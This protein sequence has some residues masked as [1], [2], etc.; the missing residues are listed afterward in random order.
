MISPECLV[1]LLL[2]E[3]MEPNE[4]ILIAGAE[5]FSTYSGYG[6]KFEYIGPYVDPN[7]IDSE[8]RRCVNIVAM[9]TIVASGDELILV[10]N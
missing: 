4:A 10:W 9:D 7:P 3:E 1:S 6:N 5:W 2:F 8:Q